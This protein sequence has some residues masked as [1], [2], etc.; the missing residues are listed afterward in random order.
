ME[1]CRVCVECLIGKQKKPILFKVTD[2]GCAKFPTEKQ[3]TRKET[4]KSN[5]RK[6]SKV[7]CE[8]VRSWVFVT[9]QT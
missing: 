7:P 3:E 1:P 5:P 8:L 2:V 4:A 9:V 6:D